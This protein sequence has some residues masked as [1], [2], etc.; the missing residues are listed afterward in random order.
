MGLRSKASTRKFGA[1]NEALRCTLAAALPT[2]SEMTTTKRF[3]TSMRP[4]ALHPGITGHILGAAAPCRRWGTTRRRFKA[5][6]KRSGSGRRTQSPTSAGELRGSATTAI[7]LP[8]RISAPPLRSTPPVHTSMSGV[9]APTFAIMRKTRPSTTT[10]KPSA[11]IPKSLSVST[12][13]ARFG[14]PKKSTTRPSKTLTKRS[15]LSRRTPHFSPAVPTFGQ[16]K[17]TTTR[18]S[19]I[20]TT[21]FDSPLT[22]R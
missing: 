6:M 9:P 17:V 12:T 19:R 21:P 5:T 1:A 7:R 2:S 4:F 20:T 8:L 13:V 11:W 10:M 18:P 14:Y 16:S 3:R 15:G 22:Q